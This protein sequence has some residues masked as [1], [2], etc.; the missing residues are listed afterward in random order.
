MSNQRDMSFHDTV[1]GRNPAPV[2]KCFIM[3][4][5]IIDRV[6]TILLVA[7][8][9]ATIHSIPEIMSGQ[10]CKTS[11]TTKRITRLFEFEPRF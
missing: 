9:F 5:P 11:F 2:H 4:Y 10:T 7:V 3:L 8:D 1:D 6:S